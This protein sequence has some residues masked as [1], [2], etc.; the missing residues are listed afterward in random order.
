VTIANTTDGGNFAIASKKRMVG[1]IIFF[2]K[3]HVFVKHMVRTG[4]FINAMGWE[5]NERSANFKIRE[6]AEDYII[7]KTLSKQTFQSGLLALSNV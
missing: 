3:Y 1:H 2:F 6:D 7:C 5:D 4:Y